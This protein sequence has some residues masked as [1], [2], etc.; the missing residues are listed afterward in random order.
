[1]PLLP[2]MK[3]MFDAQ[4]N[5][6]PIPTNL[7]ASGVPTIYRCGAGQFHGSQNFDKVIPEQAAG[8]QGQIVSFL[9][10]AFSASRL[11]G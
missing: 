2:G 3:A 1:M 9:K 6:P 8:C 7:S 5:A 11:A 10:D 4:Y